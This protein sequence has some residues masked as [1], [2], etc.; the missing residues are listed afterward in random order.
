M[1]AF[2]FNQNDAKASKKVVQAKDPNW[3]KNY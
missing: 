2:Y 1:N 3:D